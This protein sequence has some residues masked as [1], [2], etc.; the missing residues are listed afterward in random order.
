MR[1]VADMPARHV[2]AAMT[3]IRRAASL[4]AGRVRAMPQRWKDA[5]LAVGWCALDLLVFSDAGRD[6]VGGGFSDLPIM[7]FAVT[8]YVALLWRRHVPV[9]VFTAL[10]AH[11]MLAFAIPTYRPMF[12]LLVALYT[13]TA[14]RSRRSGLI[15]LALTLIP[16]GFTVA[17]EVRTADPADA[18]TVLIAAAVLFSLVNLVAWALGQWAHA[19]RQQVRLLEQQRELAAQ[20][21]AARERARVARELHDIIAHTVSVMLLQ[22]AGARRMLCDD[23][24]RAAAA[25]ENIERSGVQ[26]TGELRRLLSVLRADDS[27]GGTGSEP[28]MQHGL[29]NLP[30]LVQRLHTAGVPVRLQV[31]GHPGRLDPSVDQSAY[32]IVQESL[33]NVTKHAGR[34]AEATVELRW[35]DTALRVTVSDNGA[36]QPYGVPGRPSSGY[37]LLGLRERTAAVGGQLDA[38][39]LPGGGFRVAATLPVANAPNGAR[40]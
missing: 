6:G 21:A 40:R 11:S 32:R 38:S 23:P 2:S 8:G 39:P 28:P 37:G 25:L 10:L 9:V 5:M 26:A 13:I 36:G 35:T 17:E 16:T 27:G 3:L 20:Q 7:M 19:H 29:A 12:G 4:L 14:L 15:A 1:F 18:Q 24:Q 30:P 22:A 31:D 33:T 34:E